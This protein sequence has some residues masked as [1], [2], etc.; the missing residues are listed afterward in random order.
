M[1]DH[2][3]DHDLPHPDEPLDA[4]VARIDPALAA[5]EATADLS[6]SEQ[7]AH[8]MGMARGRLEA[9]HQM[10]EDLGRDCRLGWSL[11]KYIS[12]LRVLV[13]QRNSVTLVRALARSMGTDL[14]AEGGTDGTT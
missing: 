6:T 9:A 10:S 12:V 13:R 1:T 3:P 8:L 5:W 4:F 7:R 2:E 14:N 11:G